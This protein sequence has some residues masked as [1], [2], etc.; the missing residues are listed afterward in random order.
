MIRW[1]KAATRRG[2]LAAVA[3]AAWGIVALAACWP[4][5]VTSIQD[6][7][8]VVTVHD[9]TANFGKATYA[10]PDSVIHIDLGI[11]DL[12]DL[13]RDYD[14]LILAEV[15]RQMN[16]LGYDRRT[17]AEIQQGGADY[18]LLV[19]A[20]GRE[21][22]SYYVSYPWCGYWDWWY[23]GYWGGCYPGYYPPQVG[24]VTYQVGT[25][26]IDMIDAEQVDPDQMAFP[27]IWIGAMNGI[28]NQTTGATTQQRLIDGIE[29]AFEQSPYLGAGAGN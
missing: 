26:F 24:E 21:V 14:S 11:G 10:L 15:A 25:V 6:L 1:S 2:R 4:G 23:W 7:D 3:S 17:V 28:L 16:A 5:D 20:N 22:T 12:I 13:T 9:S 19:Q 29:R 8:V 18:V 27:R